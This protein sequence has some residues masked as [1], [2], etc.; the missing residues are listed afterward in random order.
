MHTEVTLKRVQIT[1][2]FLSAF[3]NPLT[4]SRGMPLWQ[5]LSQLTLVSVVFSTKLPAVVV[6]VVP[7]VVAAVPVVVALVVAL[8]VAVVPIVVVTVAVVLA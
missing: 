4:N 3:V 7:M 8:V 5:T 1:C 6:P 2:F